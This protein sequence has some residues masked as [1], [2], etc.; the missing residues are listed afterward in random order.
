MINFADL[1]MIFN[2]ALIHCFSRKKFFIVCPALFV[3]N[4]FLVFC[5]TASLQANSWIL[6]S[7]IFLPG[8]LCTGVLLTLGVILVR[9]YIF[10]LRNTDYS[11]KQL[12]VQS[13][14]TIV[15]VSYLSLPLICLYL[16]I[17]TFMGIFQIFKAIPGIG[18]IVPIIFSF[19]PFLL[20]C[21]FLLLIFF[22]VLVLF[23]ITPHVALKKP[24]RLRIFEEITNKMQK[25]IF[26]H[27]I[28]L[29]IA[30]APFI[31]MASVLSLSAIL[32]G[33]HYLTATSALGSSLEWI[34][35]AIPFS[36]ILAP[37]MM[38]FFHFAAECF[39]H[40]HTSQKA[41]REAEVKEQTHS[42][43]E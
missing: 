35:M 37:F 41:H 5:H 32:T 7:L 19:V 22:S 24:F 36:C 23:F 30:V 3:C 28:F 8:F 40:F 6:M 14:E 43:P 18:S 9:M 26:L 13:L 12:F 31:F 42:I 38:F 39:L 15:G 21:S 1:E 29:I 2:R 25:H 11:L 27:A 17:W 16:L 20:I 33:I 4:L 34:F 10:D